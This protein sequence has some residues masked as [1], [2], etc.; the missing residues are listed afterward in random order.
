MRAL[1]ALIVFALLSLQ[2]A[3]ATALPDCGHGGCEQARNLE[4]AVGG[5]GAQQAAGPL[6]LNGDAAS[7]DLDCS[8]CHAPAVGAGP[9]QT[10]KLLHRA[11]AARP[12]E[13]CIEPSGLVSDRPERP[14]WL[15]PKR[16]GL[17]TP[18]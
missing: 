11:A 12:P 1:V 4:H 13:R 5:D 10:L 6:V 9:G 18:T 8:H 7:L 14:Q 16:S 2:M 3:T 17:D 15:A